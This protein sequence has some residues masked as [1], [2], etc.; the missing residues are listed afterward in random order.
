MSKVIGILG[1]GEIGKS[2]AKFYQNK[3]QFA[4]LLKDL[5]FDQFGNQKI[6]IL[7]V[8]IPYFGEKEFI[9]AVVGVIK[10]NK[11]NLVIVHSTIVPGTTKKLIQKTK[12][13]IVHSPVRG[14]HPK[15]YE[16]IKTFIKFVGTEDLKTGQVVK[17]HFQSIGIKNVKTLKPAAA[18]ELN[19]LI[20][21]TYYAHCIVF[22]DYVEQ[23]FKKFHIPFEAFQD[24]NL[25]YN[26]GYKKLGKLNVAR[27]TLFPPSKT[28]R[29]IGGHCQIPNAKILE[30]LY[31]HQITKHIL[32]YQ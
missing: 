1:Y 26:E 19:K 17:K 25:S 22:T 29:R 12:A 13:K 7:N 5:K 31:P 8:A 16:G 24:F 30:K 2:V 6:D 15:L 9:T 28:G 21:T 3:K 14:V 18:T 4:L 20:D 32:K 10:K 27:P 23:I 11:P